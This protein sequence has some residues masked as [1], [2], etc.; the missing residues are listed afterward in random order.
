[1]QFDVALSHTTPQPATRSMQPRNSTGNTAACPCA[2]LPPHP[3][4]R[5]PSAPDP[6]SPH[7]CAKGHN[8]RPPCT[9]RREI[10]IDAGVLCKSA[11]TPL[12]PDA[13]H[14]TPPAPE[15]RPSS[16]SPLPAPQNAAPEMHR[17]DASPATRAH[18]R[19]PRS[20]LPR[21]AVPALLPIASAPEIVARIIPTVRGSVDWFLPKLGSLPRLLLAESQSGQD[22]LISAAPHDRSSAAPVATFVNKARPHPTHIARSPKPAPALVNLHAHK[23]VA[24]SER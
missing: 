16:S 17:D 24:A 4:A 2:N 10:R 21:P 22:E 15:P 5:A 8:T 7:C 13:A 23:A 1:M 9:A 20:P 18:P 3:T 6:T 14:A 19:V 12:P 11:H